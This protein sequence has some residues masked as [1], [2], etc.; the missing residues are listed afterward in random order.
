M[1][2]LFTL[3]LALA[4]QVTNPPYRVLWTQSSTLLS[5]AQSYRYRYYLNS[6]PGTLFGT[7]TCSGTA[8]PWNCEGALP[9]L[10]SG[11]YTIELTAQVAAE[12]ALE[13]DKSSLVVFNV[14][15]NPPIGQPTNV[16]I[17]KE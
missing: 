16:V 14:P 2:L 15:V 4:P 8:P 6:N 11:D 17:I 3:W 12:G 13:S 7:V 9:L 10:P 1:F 5:E